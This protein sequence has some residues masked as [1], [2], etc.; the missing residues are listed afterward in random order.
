[1]ESPIER[2]V[3]MEHNSAVRTVGYVVGIGV[4]LFVLFLVFC[5]T[6]GILPWRESYAEEPRP[7]QNVT[8]ITNTTTPTPEN[9]TPPQPT[10]TPTPTPETTPGTLDEEK[11]TYTVTVTFSKGGTAIPYGMSAIVENGSMEVVAVPDEGYAVENMVLD[12]VNLGPV[13]SYTLENVTANHSIYISFTRAMFAPDPTPSEPPEVDT[14]PEDQP[15]ENG[16][17]G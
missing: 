17:Y 2:N 1:M 4:L 11:P 6:T 10:Q 12:G 8:V 14:E 9:E 13:T 5:I 7:S 15:D 16:N 3:L